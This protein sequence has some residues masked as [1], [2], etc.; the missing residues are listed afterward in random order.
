MKGAGSK[1]GK[2]REF[3]MEKTA[4]LIIDMQNDFCLPGAPFEVNGAMS[5]AA[6]IK[7]PWMPAEAVI[8]QYTSSATTGQTVLM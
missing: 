4:L 6:Q 8:Y 5:V 1:T 2:R 7:K 3:A